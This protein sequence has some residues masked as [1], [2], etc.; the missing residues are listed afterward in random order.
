MWF[1]FIATGKKF[2]TR[3]EDFIRKKQ[4]NERVIYSVLS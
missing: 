1:K 3:L 2:L 4:Y